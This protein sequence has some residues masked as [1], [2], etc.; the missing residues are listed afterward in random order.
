MLVNYTSIVCYIANGFNERDY[1]WHPFN[2]TNLLFD[3]K[4]EAIGLIE[5][6]SSTA[7][8]SDVPIKPVKPKLS[9]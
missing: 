2:M 5:V 3:D 4:S 1:P 6:V 8:I 7:T 9:T